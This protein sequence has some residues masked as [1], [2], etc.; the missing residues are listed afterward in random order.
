MNPLASFAPP[1]GTKSTTSSH[2]TPSTRTLTAPGE[3]NCTSVSTFTPAVATEHI[4]QPAR[5]FG[6]INGVETHS[7]AVARDDEFF[8]SYGYGLNINLPWYIE[9]YKKFSGEHPDLV[10]EKL[11]DSLVGTGEDGIGGGVEEKKEEEEAE[12]T[13]EV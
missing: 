1:W 5:R 10:N 13:N 3:R 4:F 2:P 11:L 12:A 8:A 7:E 9:A 6:L